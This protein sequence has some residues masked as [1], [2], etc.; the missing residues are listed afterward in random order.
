MEQ[1]RHELKFVSII[2]NFK[3]RPPSPQRR[4][5]YI[6]IHGLYRLYY[7]TDIKCF[8]YYST[9]YCLWNNSTFNANRPVSLEDT[10]GIW[11]R[12]PNGGPWT[13][14]IRPADKKERKKRKYNT[15]LVLL[16]YC[17]FLVFTDGRRLNCWWNISFG[18]NDCEVIMWY[19]V[20]H[21]FSF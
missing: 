7:S 18:L 15:I 6:I 3:Y 2:L 19:F 14:Y 12:S 11:Q 10:R 1:D 20:R 16:N 21:F 5:W 17:T 8:Q 4:P 9:Y 13:N